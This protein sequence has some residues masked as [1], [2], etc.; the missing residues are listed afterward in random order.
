MENT[1]KADKP[2]SKE[3][4]CR[5]CH[6]IY[7]RRLVSGVGGNMAAR[8]GQNILLT[9]SGFSLRVMEPRSLVTV[10]PGGKIVE[11]RIPTKDAEMH[12]RIL[13]TRPGINVSLHIHGTYTVAASTLLSPGPESLPPLTPG[14]VHF[15]HPLMMLPFLVPGTVALAESVEKVFSETR[16]KALL[17][18]NHGL[19]VAGEDF[20]EALDI[21]EEIDEAA[22]IFILTKGEAKAIPS[23]NLD[24]IR[25]ASESSKGNFNEHQADIDDQSR[26][27]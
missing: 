19:V 17:L 3:D 18:Q 15:A 11:G 5:Y 10:E 22:R 24:Q 9:P 16:T 2:F 25:Q 4:F 27:N 6:L 12:L 13:R 8:S 14:F 7:D 21:A 1:N 26:N 23:E 20:D